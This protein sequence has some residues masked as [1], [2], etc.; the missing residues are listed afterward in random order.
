MRRA[1]GSIEIAFTMPSQ[2]PP[3]PPTPNSSKLTDLRDV[4]LFWKGAAPAT[5]LRGPVMYIRDLVASLLRRWPLLLCA[6]TITAAAGFF[7]VKAVPAEYE[8]TASA[9]LVP[10]KS[11]DD[12]GANR[13]LAL[14]GLNQMT[15]VLIRSLNSDETHA[16][17]Q[18]KLETSGEYVGVE[19]DWTT[20][21]TI[22]IVRGTADSPAVAESLGLRHPRAGAGL[23]DLQDRINVE[24]GARIVSLEA[25]QR[26]RADHQAQATR[27]VPSSRCP[28]ACSVRSCLASRH[29]TGSSFVAAGR[30]RRA[31]T[32]WTTRSAR[33]PPT[34]QSHRRCPR[35]H[36]NP[37]LGRF[38]RLP[39]GSPPSRPHGRSDAARARPRRAISRSILT[40]PTAVAAR[41]SRRVTASARAGFPLRSNA[42]GALGAPD[43]VMKSRLRAPLSSCRLPEQRLDLVDDHLQ[44]LS[45]VDGVWPDHLD[46]EHRA[47][48]V[49][50]PLAT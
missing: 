11:T 9:L 6:I 3:G 19:S 2:T 26:R 45:H 13:Y 31:P 12:P 10:P 22:L 49:G 43:M 24:P 18:E 44:S 8:T 47:F 27:S 1:S 7:T 5:H 38:H 17:V 29:S 50:G 21:A 32:P 4:A 20:S 35:R 14:G 25:A 36:P 16:D 42:C 39:P 33:R 40:A 30:R 41:P 48:E 46:I 23:Q 15:T 34:C 28:S 37:R